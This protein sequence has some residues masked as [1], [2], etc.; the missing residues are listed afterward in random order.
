L[1]RCRHPSLF[2]KERGGGEVFEKEKTFP[3]LIHFPRKGDRGEVFEKEKTWV[4][5]CLRQ[6]FVALL[7]QLYD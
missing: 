1:F 5:H 3:S 6:Q 4:F 2:F 7:K